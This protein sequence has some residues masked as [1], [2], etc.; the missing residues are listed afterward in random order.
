M[1]ERKANRLTLLGNIM[2]YGLIGFTPVAIIPGLFLDNDIKAE[3]RELENNHIVQRYNSLENERATR[4]LYRG[5]YGG[6][7][8]VVVGA[9]IGLKVLRR[10]SRNL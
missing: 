7:A 10:R 6:L 8:G 4:G 1:E 9:G 3:R 5:M 2:F